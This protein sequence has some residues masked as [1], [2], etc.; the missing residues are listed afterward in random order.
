M[1][2]ANLRKADARGAVF[3]RTDLHMAD[4]RGTDL[5]TANA[6]GPSPRARGCSLKSSAPPVPPGLLPVH[7]E[8]FPPP[9]AL[10]TSRGHAH[11]RAAGHPRHAGQGHRLPPH[12]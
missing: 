10:S 12:H 2:E 3:H 9:R 6:A 5:S 7:A 11:P 4:L 1:H 8:M